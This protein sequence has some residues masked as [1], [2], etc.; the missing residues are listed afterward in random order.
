MDRPPAA[1]DAAVTELRAARARHDAGLAA[2]HAEMRRTRRAG[3]S[4]GQLVAWTGYSR[5]R[6]I[7]LTVGL[8]EPSQ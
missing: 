1:L 6:V 5:R 7:Q 2:V 4:I 8:R 3:A